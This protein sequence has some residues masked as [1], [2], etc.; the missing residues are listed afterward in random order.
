MKK[1]FNKL[2]FDLLLTSG[3]SLHEQEEFLKIAKPIIKHKE[4]RKRCTPSFPHHSNTPLGV[5]ILKDALT[6]Y[7]LAINYNKTHTFKKANVETAVIIALFHD[8]YT[9]PWQNNDNTTSI[10]N[11][12]THGITHPI[13]AVLNAAKWYPKYFKNKKEATIIIDGIIHHMFPYPVRKITKDLNINNQKL[14]KNFKYYDIL[15]STTKNS[16]NCNID[17]RKPK[18]I[19]GRLMSKADKIVTLKELDTLS[20]VSALISGKNKDLVK[21]QIG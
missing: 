15:I 7:K 5:H 9:N 19:E 3:L 21:K 1:E 11:T 18:S 8:L 12:N 20:S 13:E 17:I 2:L 4:F 16:F 6:T 14:L 10:L